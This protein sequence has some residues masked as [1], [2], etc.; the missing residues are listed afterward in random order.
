MIRSR[1][2]QVKANKEVQ[3]GRKITYEVLTK[4]T[5]LSSA[6]L[7]NLMQF[8]PIKRIDGSTLDALCGFFGCG[9]GDL[10]EYVPA[11]GQ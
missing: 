6:T 4:E 2:P 9:V 10:L 11:G 5:G 1:L 8:E 7:S 3:D